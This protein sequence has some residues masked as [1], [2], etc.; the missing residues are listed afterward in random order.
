MWTQ[1]AQAQDM[2]KKEEL[3][4]AEALLIRVSSH[5]FEARKSVCIGKGMSAIFGFVLRISFYF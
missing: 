4:K 5:F 1:V 3:Q 2:M